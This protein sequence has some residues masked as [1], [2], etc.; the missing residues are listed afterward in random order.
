LE[1]AIELSGG[2][3]AN[4]IDMELL[5]QNAFAVIQNLLK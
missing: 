5:P 4:E 3:I 2:A 1:F